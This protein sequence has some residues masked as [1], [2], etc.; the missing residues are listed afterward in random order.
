M[1]PDMTDRKDAREPPKTSIFLR[2]AVIVGAAC[3]LLGVAG[4]VWLP[5]PP[6][7]PAFVRI[8]S[9]LDEGTLVRTRWTNKRGVYTEDGVRGREPDVWLFYE[10]PTGKPVSIQIVVIP[11]TGSRVIWQGPAV[12]QSNAVF[13]VER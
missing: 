7:P 1:L 5:D 10:T 8:D 13:V 9:V 12:L 3:V 4:L 6:P 2:T 11:V